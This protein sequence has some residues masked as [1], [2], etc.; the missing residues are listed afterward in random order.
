MKLNHQ[1]IPIIV[2][3]ELLVAVIVI[4]IIIIIV[5]ILIASD[6]DDRLPIMTLRFLRFFI[7]HFCVLSFITTS[8]PP[9]PP[10][11]NAGSLPPICYACAHKKRSGG[12]WGRGYHVRTLCNV[13]RRHSSVVATEVFR[14]VVHERKAHARR[15]KPANSKIETRSLI[16]VSLSQLGTSRNHC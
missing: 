4:S 13:M 11:P 16:L 5:L 8:P 7:F 2:T 9:P 3:T 15:K 14:L 10:P 6:C 1:T 12:D